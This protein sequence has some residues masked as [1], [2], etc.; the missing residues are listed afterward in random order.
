MRARPARA[1][2]RAVNLGTHALAARGKIGAITPAALEQGRLVADRRAQREFARRVKAMPAGAASGR[3]TQQ[4]RWHDLAAVQHHQPVHRAHELCIARSPA[5]APRDRQGLEH[6]AEDCPATGSTSWRRLARRRTRGIR[7]SARRAPRPTCASSTPQLAANASAATRRAT[8]R[9]R[10]S[11]RSGG[12]APG[13]PSV[14]VAARQAGD[15]HRSRRGVAKDTSA[16]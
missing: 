9:N 3:D 4:C 8:G 1:F 15:P 7:C 16:P 11:A 10:T 6:A 12:A 2:G 14:R 13:A 5:H